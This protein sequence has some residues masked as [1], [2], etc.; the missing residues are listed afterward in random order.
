MKRK[1]YLDIALLAVIF[2]GIGVFVFMQHAPATDTPTQEA[3]DAP[4]AGCC[5]A[6]VVEGETP[7]T[8]TG[9]CCGT[10]AA[11]TAQNDE[12]EQQVQPSGT[13]KTDKTSPKTP[14]SDDADE[15]GCGCGS[16]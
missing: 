8:T 4:A 13:S 14:Q 15:G 9:G 2:G 5:G 3:V 1:L 12:I 6:S 10:P 11:E 7:Q 16:Q